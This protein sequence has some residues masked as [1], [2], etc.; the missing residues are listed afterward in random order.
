MKSLGT[1]K[2]NRPP[3]LRRH[4]IRPPSD[5]TPSGTMQKKSGDSD[6]KAN[7]INAS[8]QAVDNATI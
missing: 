3:L 8:E 1:V 6:A 4:W 2:E 7:K 5:W